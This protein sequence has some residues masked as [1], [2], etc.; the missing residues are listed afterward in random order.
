MKQNK[1]GPDFNCIVFPDLKIIYVSDS[2]NFEESKN[3]LLK[4]YSDFDII[5]DSDRTHWKRCAKVIREY[6]QK[7]NIVNKLVSKLNAE[8]DKLAAVVQ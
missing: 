2:G 1:S 5:D 6:N 4:R 8:I 7:V 3:F